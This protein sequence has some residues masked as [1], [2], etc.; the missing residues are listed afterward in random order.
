MKN[1]RVEESNGQKL[2]GDV[3]RRA[4]KIKRRRRNP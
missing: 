3:E 1:C 2:Y 4:R